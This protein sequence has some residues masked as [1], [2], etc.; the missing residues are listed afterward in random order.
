MPKAVTPQTKQPEDTLYIGHGICDLSPEEQAAYRNR[1][2]V[3]IEVPERQVEQR[4]VRVPS[5][6]YDAE[7]F[8][9]SI[10]AELSYNPQYAT[11]LNRIM[12]GA[13]I[14]A[15]GLRTQTR[16]TGGEKQAD[17]IVRQG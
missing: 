12:E 13:K 15:D 7:G 17:I 16:M 9:K 10:A 14:V 5:P 1:P 6:D 4:F 2:Q 3:R 8:R 11:V